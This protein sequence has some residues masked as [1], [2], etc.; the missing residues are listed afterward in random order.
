[1][2]L[3]KINRPGLNTGIADSSDAT[4][5]TIDSA[6]S[7][8]I[9]NTTPG[10]YLEGEL[11]VGNSTK[12]QYV[13]IVTGA[14]NAAGLCF[15]D[16]TGTSIVGGLRYTHSDNNLAMWTNGSSRLVVNGNGQ[17]TMPNQPMFRVARN[18]DYT[19]TASQNIQWNHSHF[20]VGSHFNTASTY[21]FTAPVAGVYWFQAT[22][23]FNGLANGTN[24]YDSL[25]FRINGAVN[26]Y[27]T[28]RGIYNTTSMSA[29]YFVDEIAD[30][31]QLSANDTVGISCEHN[32]GIHG[33]NLYT[34]FNGFLVG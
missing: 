32:V 23:I 18:T 8:G 13:N 24:L 12:D 21:V 9:I 29:G 14:A 26:G 33:N 31:Y 11:T 22:V 3:S 6:E 34:R 16:A 28:R 30:A 7:V 4:A 1:M 27:S 17:V 5:I 15:Q 25:R 20:N 10:N 19:H 2:P